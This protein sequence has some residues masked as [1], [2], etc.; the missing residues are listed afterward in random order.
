MDDA[1]ESPP[2]PMLDD[3]FE[4]PIAPTGDQ[5]SDMIVDAL[6]VVDVRKEDA[7]DYAVSAM[8]HDKS[9]F[10]DVYGRGCD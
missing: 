4:V 7:K 3:S 9:N 1:E 8:N 5:M 10:I 6:I 2:E